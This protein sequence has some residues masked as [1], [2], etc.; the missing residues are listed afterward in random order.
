MLL[1]EEAHTAEPTKE[2]Q[3]VQQD[4]TNLKQVNSKEDLIKA[5][6]DRFDGIVHFS[7]TYHITLWNDLTIH[8]PQKC[9][10]AMQSLGHE[11]L[12]EF[13]EQGIIV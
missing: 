2:C 12:N 10:I 4:L 8:A 7:S 3:Y 11:K 1:L 6:P 5:Y 13:L 9:P